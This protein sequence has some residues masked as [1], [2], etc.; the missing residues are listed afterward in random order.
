MNFQSQPSSP[1]SSA[2]GIVPAN[3]VS[4]TLSTIGSKLSD[5]MNTV[6]QSINTSVNQFSVQAEA[7]IGASSG[8]L[9]S[10]TLIAKFAFIILVVIVFLFLLNLGI[11][12]IQYFSTAPDSPY[13]VRGMIDGTNSLTIPQDPTKPD[14]I[15]VRR[16]NNES[17]GIEFTWSVWIFV[18]ELNSGTNYIRHQH[19]FSKGNAS[20]DDMGIADVNNAPGLYLK[21]NVSNTTNAAN[22]ASLHIIMNT[23]TNRRLD[24]LVI[25]D[26]PLKKWVNVVIRMQNTVMDAYINGTVSGRLNLDAVPMQN[27]N[28]VLVCQNG[29]FSGKLSNLRY[30]AQALNI[31]EISKIAANGP[32]TT[33]NK[34]QADTSDSYSYL[35]RLWYTAKL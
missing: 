21:Q 34:A 27:F 4:N 5:T 25:N 6:S 8:F 33:A 32:D 13:L 30:Y 24:T 18:N 29:G 3:T 2:P 14:S 20:F 7:G 26:I 1:F 35:S 9:E 17:S 19:I 12:L 11:M 15:L 28:D 16:S 23:N 22:T 31:F 10:N